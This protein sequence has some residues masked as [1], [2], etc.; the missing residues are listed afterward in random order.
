MAEK[1]NNYYFK[2][3]LNSP[4]IKT[5]AKS[6]ITSSGVPNLNV[7]SVREFPVFYPSLNRQ[8]VLVNEIKGLES[9]SLNIIR[10]YESKSENLEELKKSI[11]QKAFAGEL[12]Q[13]EI[14]KVS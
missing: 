7:K 9:A 8:L 1:L 10:K 13:K 12:T 6:S 2:Y 4:I 14:A 3:Y 11:L 5:L